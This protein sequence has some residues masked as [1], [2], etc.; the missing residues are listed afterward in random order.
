MLGRREFIGTGL[1]AVALGLLGHRGTG[2]LLAQ[3]AGANRGIASSIKPILSLQPNLA[4]RPV[5]IGGYPFAPHFDGDWPEEQSHPPFIVVK[6]P[7]KP[8][9]SA[10]V[11]IVG[12]GLS[13]LAAAYML[14][15]HRPIVL[16]RLARFG[17]AS[18]GEHWVDTSYSLGG[19]YFI[20]PDKGSSLEL[21]YGELGLDEIARI[22]QGANPAELNGAIIDD[23]WTWAGIP[24]KDRP[25]FE[26]YRGLVQHYAEQYPEIPLPE[27]DADWILDLDR[28]S[29]KDHIE[30]ALGGPAPDLLASAIQAYCHS[31]FGA[32]WEEISAASGWNF[33]A[34]EEY[35][36]WV[37][38]GGNAEL[39]ERLWQRLAEDDRRLGTD[40]LRANA[41]VMD[42]R[43]TKGGAIVTYR[44]EDGALRSILAR[45]VVLACPKYIAKFIIH[46]LPLL[47][48][49][50]RDAIDQMDYRAYVVANVLLHAPIK[51][52]F[53]DLFLL[54]KGIYE[55]PWSDPE[56]FTRVTDV[57]SGH[58]ARKGPNE[59]SVLTLYWPLPWDTARFTLTPIASPLETYAARLAPQ[60]DGILGLFGLTKKAVDQ[61]RLIRWG[62]AMPIASPGFLAEER[63]L[64]VRRPIADTIFFIEQDNWALP[65]VETCLLEAETW[66]AEITTSLRRS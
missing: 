34:A 19:A 24:E 25:A 33:I 56:A 52:D 11:V 10:D 36:R 3:H 44:E 22:D 35:G 31:S 60:L 39:A 42:V 12:G 61:V 51:R 47:D 32:G 20:A 50:K 6:E 1:A 54:G 55:G 5:V 8:S 58:Y 29:L 18:Q 40:S 48:L 7:P 26:A 63:W 21:L 17:G 16:E 57:V 41:G 65:A 15:D 9:E 66:A 23:F 64:K 53:Y 38:P 43:L 27:K 2:Q 37:L 30:T 4:P 45:K 46:D 62:H 28:V 59:R 14:R 49:E 13:G